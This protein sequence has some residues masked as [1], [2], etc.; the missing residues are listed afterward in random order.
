MI[1]FDAGERERGR[2]SERARER[3][4]PKVRARP[5]GS[6][7]SFNSNLPFRDCSESC[8][9]LSST[10]VYHSITNRENFCASRCGAGL[11]RRPTYLRVFRIAPTYGYR[12]REGAEGE[13]AHR[14]VAPSFVNFAGALTYRRRLRPVRAPTPHSTY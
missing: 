1:A 13:I 12:M 4:Y 10:N 8:I 6:G 11:L 9:F 7:R 2:Q 5:R 3:T 14:P